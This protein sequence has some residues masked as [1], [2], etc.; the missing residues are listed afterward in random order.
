M[1]PLP[2]L[3]VAILHLSRFHAPDPSLVPAGP[4]AA[5][6]LSTTADST[7]KVPASKWTYAFPQFLAG[8]GGAALGGL[9]GSA[10]GGFFGFF[11][12][13]ADGVENNSECN[14]VC[15]PKAGGQVETGA[16]IGALMG[17]G[18][19]ATK[20]LIQS[21]SKAFPSKA[22]MATITGV[23]AGGGLGW[24][25]TRSMVEPDGSYTWPRWA[26]LAGT[27]SLGGVLANRSWAEPAPVVVLP[28][29]PRR[30][31]HGVMASIAF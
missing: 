6:E 17:G 2:A 5:T 23:A 30:G 8:A 1:L 16:R 24:F 15:T 27:A 12:W 7:P 19:V 9:A 13:M 28:Y 11:Y 31:T 10:I 22:P 26:I 20:F 21:S 4:T 3:L 25:A 18:L 29:A 14:T